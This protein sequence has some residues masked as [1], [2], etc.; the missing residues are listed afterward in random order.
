MKIKITEKQFDKI[1]S[2]LVTS[3]ID[4]VLAG[5]AD[6]DTIKYYFSQIASKLIN[7]KTLPKK[8]RIYLSRAFFRMS[9]SYDL[10]L[11]SKGIIEG[12]VKPEIDKLYIEPREDCFIYLTSVMKKISTI[13]AEELQAKAPL[14]VS[15]LKSLKTNILKITSERGHTPYEGD[16][17]AIALGLKINHRN[18]TDKGKKMTIALTVWRLINSGN[19]GEYA[20][21]VVAKEFNKKPATIK[22]I[23]MTCKK[24]IDTVVRATIKK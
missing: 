3:D 17:P 11:M 4:D 5:K 8:W 7:N 13:T 2:K 21:H 1:A 22:E 6:N 20:Y 14:T 23:Y 15:K 9:K 24:Q 18:A 19:K 10:C 16:D 12:K